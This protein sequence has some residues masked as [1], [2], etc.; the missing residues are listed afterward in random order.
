MILAD[1]V[2][3][4]QNTTVPIEKDTVFEPL[5]I[6]KNPLYVV[7]DS[8]SNTTCKDYILSTVK[9]S[10]ASQEQRQSIFTDRTFYHKNLVMSE[11]TNVVNN[12][13]IFALFLFFAFLSAILLRFGGAITLSFLQGCFSKNQLSISTRDGEN[14]HP[15]ALIPVSFIFL[16]LVSFVLFYTLDYFDLQT[17]YASYLS[18]KITLNNHPFFLWLSIYVGTLILYYSKII[19]IKLLS[20][21]F[22]AKK[23]S[24]YYVQIQLNFSILMGF[25]I[26]LPA[27]CLVYAGN[28]TKELFLI[29]CALIIVILYVTKLIRLTTVIIAGFKFSYLYL[30]FY[31]CTLELLPIILIGKRLFF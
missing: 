8:G 21:I 14:I 10:F 9:D 27:F 18:Q 13:W 15:L 30:F 4:S 7:A 24:N 5:Y 25:A 6:K 20:Q 1:S 16:P 11:N 2:N 29:I 3:I 12:D 31:L 23:I 19:L 17:Q 22:R 26:F 28:W